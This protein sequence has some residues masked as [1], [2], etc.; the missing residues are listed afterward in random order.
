M[1]K[2]KAARHFLFASET[3]I[4]YMNVTNSLANGWY[5]SYKVFCRQVGVESWTSCARRLVQ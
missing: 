2:R 1:K 3:L 4:I 5:Q